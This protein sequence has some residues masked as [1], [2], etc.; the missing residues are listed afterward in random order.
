MRF[1]LTGA[2]GFLGRE[3]LVRL[4]QQGH[5]VLVLSRP[6]P[7]EDE[8]ALH[9]RLQA[10]VEHT[11]PG[12]ST[13]T[14][15]VASGDIRAPDLGLSERGRRFLEEPG[16]PIQVVHGAAE[17]R[18]DLPYPEMRQQNVEG[19]LAVLALAR[20]L[21]DEGRLHRFDHVST[22]YVAGDRS[23]LALETEVDVGQRCR[24]D[25]ERTKLEAEVQLAEARAQG[26]PLTVHRPSIIV[27]DS[28]TGK[29]SSFKVLYWPLKLYAR[30]RFRTVFG[31]P[32]CSID[33][34]PV[35]YVADAM[36]ALFAMPAATGR[37]FH[38][39]AGPER[40]S[41]IAALV[42]LTER[43]YQGKPVRYL[44]PDFYF[45]WLRPF[46]RPLLLLLRP[47]V[48]ERGGVYLPYLKANP[49]FDVT[50]ASELLA[51]RGLSPPPVDSYWEVILR[52]A[53]DT[54]FGSQRSLP[55]ITP[56]RPTG[57]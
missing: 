7:G 52:Y 36:L 32:D 6:K 12:T 3:V 38:L 4:L 35:D 22:A 30:G 9:Q 25:Y 15:T 40:Q 48:A 11:A 51:P 10:V 5:P 16:A 27:G 2:T 1:F 42:A 57:S 37:I 44:D 8:D 56:D 19:T 47:D 50:Q 28:R 43:I 20:R 29:A 24:N 17:V 39:T 23:G 54:N 33:V 26:L 14:M 46:V 45:R 53:R 31:R 13:A 21:A 18:F 49:S 41:T 34:V 55:A